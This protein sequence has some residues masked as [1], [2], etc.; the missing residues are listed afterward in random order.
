MDLYLM[1]LLPKASVPPFFLIQNLTFS[2]Y[3][4]N[5]KPVYT[6]SRL[7]VTADNVTAVTGE[8]MPAWP[9]TQRRFNLCLVGIV[10]NGATKEGGCIA[11]TP[12][13]TPAGQD[14]LN[15]VGG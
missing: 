3:D 12:K 15:A 8:R 7:N 14:L 10:Q 1:G 2:N 11:I 6:G 9:N 5:N 4:G 13:L